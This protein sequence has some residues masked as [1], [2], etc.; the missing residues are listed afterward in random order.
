[1]PNTETIN[2]PTS[3]IQFFARPAAFRAWLKKNHTKENELIVGFHKK[4]T[5]RPSITWPESVA[6][7]LCFGWIDGIRR[8][9]SDESYTVRFTPRRKG[10]N[11]SAVNIRLIAELEAA[12]RMTDAG[13]AAFAARPNPE[14]TGYAYTKRGGTLDAACLAKFKKRK[15]AWTFFEKQPPS[16]RNAVAW[17]VISL[18]TLYSPAEIRLRD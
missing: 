7:A 9:H 17:W 11:W 6:E 4:H 2:S 5:A 15:S 16:Y 10:S 3:A 1:M 13:R 12:G 8:S 18:H 14:S